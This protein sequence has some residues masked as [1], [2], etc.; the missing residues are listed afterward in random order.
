MAGNI[1]FQVMLRDLTP[2]NV[3]YAAALCAELGLSGLP[4]FAVFSLTLIL[5]PAESDA[6]LR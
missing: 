4:S 5:Q 3:L 1:K 6:L 2:K